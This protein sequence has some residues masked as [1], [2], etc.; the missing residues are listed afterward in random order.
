MRVEEFEGLIYISFAMNPPDFAP[1]RALMEPV[2]RP[3]GLA[4][5]KI[6]KMADYMVGRAVVHGERRAREMEE[7]SETLRAIGVEPIMAEAAARRQQWSAQ[8]G[9]RSHFGSEGPRSAAE[10]VEVVTRLTARQEESACDAHSS[11]Q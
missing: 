3:Q 1:A 9:L 4:R 7:V 5:T 8:L 6:A 11:R 2:L 10:V